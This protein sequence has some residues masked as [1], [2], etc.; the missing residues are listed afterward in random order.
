[1][2]KEIPS[3]SDISRHLE[4][5]KRDVEVT[6]QD[7]YEKILGL[8]NNYKITEFG[9]RETEKK[10]N[11]MKESLSQAMR[12]REIEKRCYDA[13]E[14][15]RL[16]EYEK[17]Q[18]IK[19]NEF[20]IKKN[21]EISDIIFNCSEE[22]TKIPRFDGKIENE[23]INPEDVD[24]KEFIK[25]IKTSGNVNKPKDA[26]NLQPKISK[27]YNLMVVG[28]SGVGKT[29]WLFKLAGLDTK[30]G[31][32]PTHGIAVHSITR[33]NKSWAGKVM[34]FSIRDFPGSEKFDTTAKYENV[35]AAIVMF[36]YKSKTSYFNVKQWI[37]NVKLVAG[38]IPIVV[39]G[40]KTDLQKH[41]KCSISKTVK[42]GAMKVLKMSAMTCANFED[43]INVI[44]EM[45]FNKECPKVIDLVKLRKND[46][47][48]DGNVGTGNIEDVKYD[49]VV[50]SDG[51]VKND[52]IV[53]SN[54]K[55]NIPI[56]K[57]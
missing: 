17:E 19:K 36:D 52:V 43:P 35:S 51:N 16:I 39:V 53:K 1:M 10:L 15:I 18:Y 42:L 14:R 30:S 21:A 2:S 38:N 55:Q 4:M 31:C 50:N 54:T 13:L 7:K 8:A 46:V 34:H 48:N 12:K 27:P 3:M 37:D 9:I 11:F 40:N 32:K 49:G 24:L 20:L 45:I 28:D 6:K 47:M 41:V 23:E 25:K 5:R 33:Y 44:N 57:K 26:V 29:T 22:I 56:M